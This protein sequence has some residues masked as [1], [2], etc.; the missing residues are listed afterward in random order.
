LDVGGATRLEVGAESGATDAD[1]G[2]PADAEDG[3]QTVCMPVIAANYDQSCAE[4]SDCLAVPEIPACPVDETICHNFDTA[5][6]SLR[7]QAQYDRAFSR[8]LSTVPPPDGLVLPCSS[9]VGQLPCCLAGVRH[10]D[11]TTDLC[12]VRYP[13]GAV[14]RLIDGSTRE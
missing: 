7:A 3:E 12:P 2:G 4:D 5:A 9:L 1:D 11:L 10:Y 6:I 8:A 13:D 14:L